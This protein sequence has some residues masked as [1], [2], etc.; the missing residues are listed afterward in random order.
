[1]IKNII[2]VFRPLRWYRNI[3]ILVGSLLAVKILGLTFND[4]AKQNLFYPVMLALVSACLVASGNYGI[5]EILDAETDKF[6]PEKKYRAIPSGR[7]SKRTV[8]F[9]SAILYIT[10]A[11][12]TLSINR[13]YLTVSM[14]L[15][16]LSGIF[17][18]LKPLR[19]KDIPYID[20]IS[21][22]LNNPIRLLIGW[23][24]IA[25][26][27]EIV[28]SSFVLGYWSFGVFLMAAKRFGE[29]RLIKD[30]NISAKYRNSL[31][32]YTQ[33]TLLLSMIGALVSFSYMFGALSMKYSIDLLIA[34]PFV[35]T[36]TIWFFK[37]AYQS[38]T[39]VKDPERIF[40]NKPYLIFSIIL[41]TVFSYLFITG[42]Q[43]LGWIK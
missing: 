3:F 6:H 25:S 12:I 41:A 39:I 29:I 40:E 14:S 28:P 27:Q 4:I 23:Y 16:F 32:Y 10:G 21:E 22:A 11:T 18:N 9:I 13:P 38:N 1:M 26:S 7:I 33:E 17:Y 42:N 36:W 35:T 37:L 24:A 34:L 15:L 19:L 2:D 31:R 5:N 20:F 30:A 8:L 43:I